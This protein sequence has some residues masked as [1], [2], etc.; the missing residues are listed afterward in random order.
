MQKQIKITVSKKM[1]EILEKRAKRM[2]LKTAKYC[3][4]LVFENL[5]KEVENG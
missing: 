5:R 1:N 2:G 4:N 3:F